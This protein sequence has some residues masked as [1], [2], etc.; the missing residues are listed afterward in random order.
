MFAVPLGIVGAG[1]AAGAKANSMQSM[2]SMSGTPSSAAQAA[3]MPAWIA[4][5]NRIGP[6]LLIG[7]VALVI[8]ALAFRRSVSG[9][10]T[11]LVAGIILYYGMYSQTNMRLMWIAAATGF[12]LLLV[13]MLGLRH[14]THAPVSS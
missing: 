10:I 4:L 6:E 3:N 7:S 9:T 5:L 2:E 1:V 11:S 14:T 13:S 12:V 8:L